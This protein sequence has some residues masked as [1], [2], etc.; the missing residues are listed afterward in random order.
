MLAFS[1]VFIVVM[2]FYCHHSLFSQLKA[3]S[4]LDVRLWYFWFPSLL[5]AFSPAAVVIVIIIAA[6]M[7]ILEPVIRASLYHCYAH[8][9]RF[10]FSFYFTDCLR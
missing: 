7:A 6:I 5:F 10:V 8:I 3:I 1:A 9:Y 4:D 2:F